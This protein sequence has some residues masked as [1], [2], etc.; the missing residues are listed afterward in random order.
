MEF[1]NV[2]IVKNAKEHRV[3]NLY[4]TNGKYSDK[5]YDKIQADCT[6]LVAYPSLINIHDHLVGNWVPKGAPGRPY[7]NTS[8]WVEELNESDPVKE[9]DKYLKTPMSHLMEE[10]GLD[11]AMLGVYKNIFSGVTIIQDHVPRQKEEYYQS[12][13]I[14]VISDFQQGHSITGK[15]WWGGDELSEEMKKTKG[16]IPFIIHLAE[17]SDDLARSEFDG[18]VEQGLLKNN[19]ILVHCTAITTEQFK[20]IKA[21]GASIA[22][23]PNSN[24]YLLGITLDIDTVLKLGINIC[25]GTDSTLSGSTNLLKEIMYTKQTFPE[26]SNKTLFKMVTENPAKALMLD[27]YN[28]KIEPDIDANLLLTR[29]NKKDPYENFVTLNACDIELLMH[30]GKPIFGKVEYLKYF[31]W[32]AKDYYLFEC[33]D[34]KMFVTGHPEDILK[35]IEKKLGYKKHFDYLPF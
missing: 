29:M 34:S 3:N 35:K 6:G 20:Q 7:S 1:S 19:S 17:G 33:N 11:L 25:L 27:T 23:C 16:E 28:G 9:R 21:A 22:W 2:L 14:K 10:A 30:V 15:N 4:V 26:I 13:P 32:D 31:S 8:I 12:F 24:I 18:L 5:S